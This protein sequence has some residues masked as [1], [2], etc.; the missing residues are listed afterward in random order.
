MSIL[1]GR[2]NLTVSTASGESCTI[3]ALTNGRVDQIHG[4]IERA[5]KIPRVV[6]RLILTGTKGMREIHSEEFLTQLP[7]DHGSHITVINSW[8]QNPEF[9]VEKLVAVAASPATHPIALAVSRCLEHEDSS[10]QLAALQTL[11]W[12]GRFAAPHAGHIAKILQHESK[13]IRLAA[14]ESLSWLEEVGGAYAGEIVHFLLP[15]PVR[16]SIQEIFLGNFGAKS[17]WGMIT[18]VYIL[19]KK[20]ELSR[21]HQEESQKSCMGG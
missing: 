17:S 16:G 12:M 21:E 1:P 6:Q 8:P 4:A 18:I 14:A 10:V 15:A 20:C 3:A 19:E 11:S 7:L 13:G 9:I 2:V 5:L